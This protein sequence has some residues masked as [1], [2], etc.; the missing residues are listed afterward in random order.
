MSNQK[1]QTSNRKFHGSMDIAEEK[2]EQLKQIFPEAFSQGKI[3]FDQLKRALG[4]W[5]D[6]GKERLGLN[7]PGKAECMKIIQ[8]PSVATLKPAR[9]EDVFFR[10]GP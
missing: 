8:Q 1:S 7:W 3:D 6:P 5:V 9:D 4:E 10:D 2:R